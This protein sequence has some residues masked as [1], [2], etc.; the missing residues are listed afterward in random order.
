MLGV[1]TEY[2]SVY[3]KLTTDWLS[4]F[5]QAWPHHQFEL[6]FSQIKVTH[7]SLRW[8]YHDESLPHKDAVK[9]K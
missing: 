2:L 5:K 8:R 1:E 7:P 4:N 9:K 6:P 3:L